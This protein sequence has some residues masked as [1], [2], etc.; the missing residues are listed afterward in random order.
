MIYAFV[1]VVIFSAV[2][3]ACCDAAKTVV[4][5][6]RYRRMR[7][8]A[9]FVRTPK[10]GIVRIQLSNGIIKKASKC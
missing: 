1:L 10:R 5:K 2:V 9:L 6:R 3:L 8:A 4:A 7:N